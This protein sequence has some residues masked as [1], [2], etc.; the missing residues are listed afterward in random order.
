MYHKRQAQLHV[1]LRLNVSKVSTSASVNIQ[2]IIEA[3]HQNTSLQLQEHENNSQGMKSKEMENNALILRIQY[4]GINVGYVIVVVYFEF[5]AGSTCK[6]S[7]TAG[8]FSP[9]GLL[10]SQV[11]SIDFLKIEETGIA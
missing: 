10:S 9:R 2:Q 7:D 4:S 11:F 1:T 8:A 5:N 3:V 6:F